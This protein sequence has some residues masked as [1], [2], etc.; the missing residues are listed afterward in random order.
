MK[1][2]FWLLFV[3]CGWHL[4]AAEPEVQWTPWSDAVFQRARAEHRFVLLD[5]GA[6]WCHWCHVMDEVTYRDPKVIAL[7]NK[8]YIAVRVDQDARPDLANRYQN[9]GW[10]ATIV[11]AADGS[12][13]VKRQ[14]YIEPRAM[15]SLLQA[16][17]DDPTP[18][19]SV[20]PEKPV[21]FADAGALT[22][23]QREEMRRR[24][25]AAYDSKLGGWGHEDKFLDWNALL[26]CLE[27]AS[28]GDA[29]AETMCRQ[30]LKSGLKLL[31]PVWG[32]VYQ[33]STD[34]DWDHPHFE[35]IMPFQ[36]ENM[37]V[38]SIAYARWHDPVYLHAAQGIHRFL[39][40]F[41]TNPDGAFYVSED[42][43]LVDGQH[44]AGYFALD[45]KGR[46]KLGVPRI[47]K[48]IYARENGLGITGLAAL[49][50]ASGDENCLAEAR[51]AADWV[52]ANRSLPDGGFRHDAQDAAGP[53]L[54]DTLEMARA[55][56]QLYVVTGERPWLAKAESASDF[57]NAHFKAVA[58]FNSVAAAADTT[59]APR[60]DPDENV[61]VALWAN[62]LGHYSGRTADH[63]M[64][65]HAMRYLAAPALVAQ[66]GWATAPVLLA[67]LELNADPQHITIVGGK[68]DPLARSLFA[69]AIA[70][71]A[72][73]NQTE[74]FDVRD[75]PLPGSEISYPQLKEA[76]AF[77]C[78]GQTCSSPIS[79]ASALQAKLHRL[80]PK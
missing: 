74:W 76:A 35:K 75:G 25:F 59:F 72:V 53:Y 14:G 12:E 4:A 28:A 52:L 18:G 37:R 45:D 67:D 30:T 39:Q 73:Y 46:R 79:E 8:S 40:N 65:Q 22:G 60:P 2:R 70:T 43:D 23:E 62:L 44:S 42:A 6:V 71:P 58:G 5:L 32:G 10:P 20:Q 33:Y 27:N 78:S 55:F 49:F 24:F 17:I 13:I 80:P 7:I 19:P 66:R 36:A 21:T 69:A 26:Y 9:Y 47:D 77:L 1:N 34:G 31:D 11:F 38:F 50:A 56:L 48:H 57:I 29:R 64:A 15:A 54:A 3:F 16:I 68:D 61:A 51:R 41:L 63:A